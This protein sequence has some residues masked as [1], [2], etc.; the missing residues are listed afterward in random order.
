M[1][2]IFAACKKGF[3]GFE[4]FESLQKILFLAKKILTIKISTPKAS[5]YVNRQPK[6]INL[7]IRRELWS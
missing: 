1:F 5:C 3:V 7:V 6:S 2:V 4:S